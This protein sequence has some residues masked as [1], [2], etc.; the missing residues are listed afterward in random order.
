[1]EVFGV[2]GVVIEEFSIVCVAGLHVVDASWMTC[3]GSIDLV[4]ASEPDVS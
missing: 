4:L 3:W 2:F 1:M